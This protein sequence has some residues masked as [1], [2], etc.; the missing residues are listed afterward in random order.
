MYMSYCAF[1]DTFTTLNC[2]CKSNNC[3]FSFRT[4]VYSD[5]DFFGGNSYPRVKEIN[6]VPDEPIL[7][8]GTAAYKINVESMLNDKSGKW[9]PLNDGLEKIYNILDKFVKTGVYLIGYGITSFDLKI[10]NE[11]F[12]RVL[13]KEPIQFDETHI[14]DIAKLA[15]TVVNVTDCG[16]YNQNSIAACLLSGTE[17]ENVSSVNTIDRNIQ[18]TKMIFTRLLK[19]SGLGQDFGTISSFI[20]SPHNVEFFQSGKYAGER[21]EDVFKADRQYLSWILKNKQ[22]YETDPDMLRKVSELLNSEDK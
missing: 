18:M 20:S 7:G 3:P 8:N 17:F 9:I 21:I 5:E 11:N 15:K 22:F 16:N 10:L 4:E 19:M 13:N 2:L 12:K 1:I 6:M 14:I